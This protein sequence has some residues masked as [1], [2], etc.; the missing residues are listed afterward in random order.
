VARDLYAQEGCSPYR[1]ALLPWVQLP[2]WITL[3]FALRNMA[4]V[5]PGRPSLETVETALTTEG[6]LWFQDLTVPDPC[7]VLPIILV[8]SN[9]CNIELHALRRQTPSRSQRIFTNSLRV[10]SVAMLFVAT[11]MPS[12]M[13]LYWTTS[14]TF[15]LVQNILFNFPR[16]RRGLKIPRTPSESQTPFRDLSTT[17]REKARAFII[18]QREAS[19]K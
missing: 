19:Q 7:Y 4:G 3:S 13:T 9:L 5:L 14:S 2:L 6:C 17:V 12:V 11:Q 10:L 15:G 18:L 16:V 1:V 8:A